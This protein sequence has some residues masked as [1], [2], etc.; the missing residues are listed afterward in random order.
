MNPI[1]YIVR[2]TV[3]IYKYQIFILSDI[4]IFRKTN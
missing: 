2:M 4:V 1:N 3:I